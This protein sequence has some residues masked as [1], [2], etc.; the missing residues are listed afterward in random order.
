MTRVLVVDDH[1]DSADSLGQV[2][3]TLGYDASMAYDGLEAVAISKTAHPDVVILDIEMPVMD[4]FN[5]ARLLRSMAPVTLIALTAMA[6][7]D[8][9]AQTAAAGFDFYLSKPA[10]IDLLLSILHSV[11][12]PPGT[13]AALEAVV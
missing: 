12:N 2:L 8:I 1:R 6:S 5:A 9:E 4:G 3:K 13:A 11:A 10:D 7:A